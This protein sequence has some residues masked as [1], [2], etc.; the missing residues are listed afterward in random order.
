LPDLEGKVVSF[1]AQ[2]KEFT[3]V[4]DGPSGKFE[5]QAVMA[6]FIAMDAAG[7]VIRG[8]TN[9][10]PPG[11]RQ[12]A[13]RLQGTDKPWTEAG[14]LRKSPHSNPTKAA[15]GYTVW[16]VE[17]IEEAQLLRVVEAFSKA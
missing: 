12:E 8:Y 7:A 9:L 13:L 6:A 15:Q 17:P 2:G 5:S 4:N 3:T 11:L 10:F 14:V 16:V 1:M